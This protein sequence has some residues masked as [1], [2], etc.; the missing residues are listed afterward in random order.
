MV[1]LRTRSDAEGTFLGHD[2]NIFCSAGVSP[3][4]ILKCHECDLGYDQPITIMGF[5]LN[6]TELV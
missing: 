1:N 4:K 6:Q 3:V 5:N 2:M